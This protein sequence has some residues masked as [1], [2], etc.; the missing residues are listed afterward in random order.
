MRALL[1]WG[2][3]AAVSLGLAA[4]ALGAD[5]RDAPN[6]LFE[7]G[8]DRSLDVNDIYVFQAPRTK[9]SVLVM[10]VN[11]F[12][13]PGDETPTFNVGGSYEFLIDR[14][15]D[16]IEEAAITIRFG[17]PL[18][19]RQSMTV[20]LRDSDKKKKKPKL[21][22]RGR[23]GNTVH[24]RGGGKL[25]CDI[26]D[27][28]FFFDLQ[29]FRDT[30]G[31]VVG[32]RRFNDGHEVDFF[33]NVNVSAIVLELDA[34]LLAMENVRVWGRTL[35]AAGHQVDRTAIPVVNT[36][37]IPGPRKQEFNEAPPGDDVANFTDEV[38]KTAETV[39]GRTT[40]DA[41][42]L[43]ATVLPDTLPFNVKSNAGFLNGRKLADDVGDI[44]LGL[45]TNGAITTDGIDQ[46]DAQFS[47]SFPYL[48]PP[49]QP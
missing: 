45:V 7:N 40:A 30:V 11:P 16:G 32:G 46:N 8:G 44:L 24:V 18:R 48:A 10:T 43:A 3:C 5:H 13:A 28:P 33:G 47:T 37:F 22:A 15:N 19:G 34:E 2:C 27:D 21:L 17:A 1:R 20:F 29:A 23:T 49:Q 38:V 14:D 9:H 36:V 4:A 41:Q 25:Q 42:A 6:L 35:D 12:I 39:F 31:G 26:F